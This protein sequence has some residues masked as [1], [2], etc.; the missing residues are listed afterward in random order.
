[1]GG[2]YLH[3]NKDKIGSPG[4][5]NTSSCRDL[6]AFSPH[7]YYDVLDSRSVRRSSLHFMRYLVVITN[8]SLLPHTCR[9]FLWQGA[10]DR[11]LPDFFKWNPEKNII[12][13]GWV[14]FLFTHLFHGKSHL[15]KLSVTHFSMHGSPQVWDDFSITKEEIK[16]LNTCG[17]PF[18]V[19]QQKLQK[20]FWSVTHRFGVKWGQSDCR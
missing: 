1:M 5:H 18:L 20:K 6:N 13:E 14:E 7:I 4:L 10:G 17:T 2:G 3:Q 15:V 11:Q 12:L 16:K 8:C 19:W 9:L